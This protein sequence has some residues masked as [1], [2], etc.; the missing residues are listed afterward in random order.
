[1]AVA[2]LLLAW[3]IGVI[4]KRVISWSQYS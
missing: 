2:A 1:M 4:E 3:L